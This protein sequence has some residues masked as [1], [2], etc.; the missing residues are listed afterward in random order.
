MLDQVDVDRGACEQART[1]R[2]EKSQLTLSI[3]SVTDAAQA[4]A[5]GS[6]QRPIGEG[7]SSCRCQGGQATQGDYSHGSLLGRGDGRI[8]P[9]VSIGPTARVETQGCARERPGCRRNPGN[10]LCLKE[11]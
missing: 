10:S 11:R 4:R 9:S 2:R 5:E 8:K 6:A 3:S 7:P 1:Q